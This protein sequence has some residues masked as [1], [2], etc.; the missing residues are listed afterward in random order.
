MSAGTNEYIQKGI[1]SAEQATIEDKAHNYE[2]AAKNYVTA[3][4]WLM[5]AV[6]YGAMNDA[7]KQNIRSKVDSYLKRAEEIK[8]NGSKKKKAVAEGGNSKDNKDDDE[9][10]DPDRKRMMQ[11]F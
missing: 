10:S 3:A 8:N 4:E 1:A 7:L 6:K 5:H 11:K 2:A 9:S